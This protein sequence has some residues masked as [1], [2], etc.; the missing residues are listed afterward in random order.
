M[1]TIRFIGDCHG[2]FA[3]YYEI[4]RDSEYSIQ[5]GDFGFSEA[6]QKLE[7]LETNARNR[8]ELEDMSEKIQF[9]DNCFKEVSSEIEKKINS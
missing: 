5:V 1:K 7:E 3:E 6:H 4:A 8:E 9:V 2:N